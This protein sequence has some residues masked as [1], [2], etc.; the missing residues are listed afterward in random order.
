MFLNV[1]NDRFLPRT[2]DLSDLSG[3]NNDCILVQM[4]FFMKRS[5]PVK[6]VWP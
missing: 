2:A 5:R 4:H 3:K 1:S 6:N